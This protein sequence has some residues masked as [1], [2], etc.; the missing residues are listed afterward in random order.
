MIRGTLPVRVL[1]D[2]LDADR[3]ASPPLPL[4]NPRYQRFLDRERFLRFDS[5]AFSMSQGAYSVLNN[6]KLSLF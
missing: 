2:D 5:C 1:D 3:P 4:L 6:L